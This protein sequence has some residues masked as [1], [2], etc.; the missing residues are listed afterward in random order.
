MQVALSGTPVIEEVE[1]C[2]APAF[3]GQV[4]NAVAMA[5]DKCESPEYGADCRTEAS[6]RGSVLRKAQHMMHFSAAEPTRGP[7]NEEIFA[8]GEWVQST[9]SG[10][11][12][13]PVPAPDRPIRVLV[14]DDHRVVRE[15]LAILLG[16]EPDVT[17]VGQAENERVALE[18]V[19]ELAPDVVIMDMNMPVL[20]GIQATRRLRADFPAVRVVASSMH[21]ERDGVA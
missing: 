21:E 13:S 15:G 2:S 10:P 7:L 5:G 14:V 17:V 4:G 18:R 8:G 20:D 6:V 1:P 11:E 12:A 9:A 3:L 16:A 19:P